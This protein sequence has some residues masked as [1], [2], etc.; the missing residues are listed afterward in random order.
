M[1]VDLIVERL[2]LA[3]GE[4]I[5]E[6][7][8]DADCDNEFRS[9]LEK[10]TG[11]KF[12]ED[13][14]TEVVDAVLLWWRDGDGDLVDDLMDALTYLSETGP[15]WLLTPK[16]GRDGHVEPSDIQEAAPTAGLS[17]TVSFAIGADWTATKLVA[18]KS[19][20]K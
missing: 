9:A 8:L 13:A 4:L 1:G 17:Q 20:R 12:I 2:A 5:L 15:I 19:S 10:R 16:V 7:G 3:P 6:V 18:R 11:T 14:A